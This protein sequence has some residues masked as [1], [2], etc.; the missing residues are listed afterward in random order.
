[1]CSRVNH[2]QSVCLSVLVYTASMA[3]HR[4]TWLPW[5]TPAYRGDG[6]SIGG[7]SDPPGLRRFWFHSML[8]LHAPGVALPPSVT[9][10]QSLPVFI[11]SLKPNCL[12]S[13]FLPVWLSFNAG[14][15]LQL[16]CDTDW[17]R[18]RSLWSLYCHVSLND[19]SFDSNKSK[20][21]RIIWAIDYYYTL[22]K[23]NLAV[24]YL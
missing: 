9:S 16:M 19:I 22:I 12:R 18:L 4:P 2:I 1:M 14:W 15:T 7:G 6:L 13:H 24:Y 11:R 20:W 3:K 10:S 5:W 17:L 8:P 23:T 21:R